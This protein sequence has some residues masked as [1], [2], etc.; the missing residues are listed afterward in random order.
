MSTSAKQVANPAA[1]LGEAVGKLFENAV[2]NG[3]R[4]DVEN[5][6]HTIRP[7]KLTN[8]TGN[9]YQID[10][11]VFDKNG[12]PIIII[13][14]KYIRYTKHNRDKGSW[15]CTAHYNLRKTFP[16]IRKSIAVLAGR[17]SVPSRALVRSFGVELMDVPFSRM[18]SVLREYGIDFNWAEK[19][20]ETPLRSWEVFS[21]L[22]TL[23]REAIGAEFTEGVMGDLRNAVNNVLDTDINSLPS[24]VS[25]VEILL[26]TDQ[27]EMLLRTFDSIVAS[28]QHMM[29]LVSDNPDISELLQS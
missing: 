10:A 20:K 26:K 5:R 2:T 13:D 6:D 16:S 29:Q 1:A 25:S 3:L 22:E 23:D 9:T 28:L 4:Q 14:P 7:A 27:D 24:R 19:D 8:G 18:V 11:V 12:N 21:A 17:W 15:L